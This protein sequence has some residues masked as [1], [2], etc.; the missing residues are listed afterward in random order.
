MATWI[1]RI[2]FGVI[3]AA[4]TRQRRQ[5]RWGLTV[6]LVAIIVGLGAYA[7]FGEAGT[8]VRYAIPA[9]G[10]VTGE[11]GAVSPADYQVWVTPGLFPGGPTVSVTVQAAP[12]WFSSRTEAPYAGSLTPIADVEPDGWVFA[13]VPYHAARVDVLVVA[14]RVAAIRVGSLGIAAARSLR[15]LPPGERVVAFAVPQAHISGGVLQAPAQSLGLV[16]ARGYSDTISVPAHRDPNPAHDVTPVPQNWTSVGGRCATAATLPGL[17]DVQG[18]A[19]KTIV[20]T[21]ASAPGLLMSCVEDRYAYRGSRFSV[22]ILLNAH[23]PGRA[24]APLWGTIAVPRH[25]GMVELKPPSQFQTGMNETSPLFAR[26]VGDAWLVVQ[27]RPGFA[28]N[29]GFAQTVRVLD[30]VRIARVDL[31]RG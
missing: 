10:T 28:P 8:R 3:D 13:P 11:L 2:R 31:A 12:G 25:P 15:G 27:A 19:S 7:A 17:T 21:P 26:R 6:L 24:P 16:D 4:R 29:P 20:A 14:S 1:G 18:W 5:R 9:P 30:S 22:A 23:H